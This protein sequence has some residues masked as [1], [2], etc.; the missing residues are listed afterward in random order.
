MDKNKLDELFDEAFPKLFAPLNEFD[1]DGKQREPYNERIKSFIWDI[2]G[3]AF[4][5]GKTK[6]ISD[7]SDNLLKHYGHE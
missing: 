6:G 7:C 4:V 2:Y 3:L 5:E 1:K